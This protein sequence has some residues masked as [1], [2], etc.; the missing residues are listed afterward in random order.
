MHDQTLRNENSSS[1]YYCFDDAV[2]V[3]FRN[4]SNGIRFKFTWEDIMLILEIK[5]EYYD[6]CC[7][8]SDESSICD[9]PVEIDED[10]LLSYII[11]HASQNDL[12]LTE[13][14]LSEILDAELVYFEQ[15]GALRDAGEYLN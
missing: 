8:P 15:N 14:E 12:L 4:I 9:F 5:D 6:L 7:Q 10:E 11:L 3:I 2:E 1:F 13:S